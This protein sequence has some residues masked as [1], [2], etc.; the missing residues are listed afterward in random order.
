LNSNDT[1]NSSVTFGAIQGWTA[2]DVTVGSDNVTRILWSS[3]SSAAIWQVNNS[4]T[5]TAVTLYSAP[6]GWSATALAAG[7]DGVVRLL[8]DNTNGEASLWILSNSGT[9]D[10]SGTWGPF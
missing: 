1:Y 3:G 4:F 2:T 9:Y 8:W 7:S 6:S 10:T 5:V